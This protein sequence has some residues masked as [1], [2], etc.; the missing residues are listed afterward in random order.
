MLDTHANYPNMDLACF[1]KCLQTYTLFLDRFI[2]KTF[3]SQL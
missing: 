3:F 2:E 1:E